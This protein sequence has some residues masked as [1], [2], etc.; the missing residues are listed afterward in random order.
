[1]TKII[2]TILVFLGLLTGCMN[3]PVKQDAGQ[4]STK[5]LKYPELGKK[6]HLVSNGIFLLKTDYISGYRYKLATELNVSLGFGAYSVFI[7]PSEE[8]IPSIMEGE[9]YH[10]VTSYALKQLIG[11]STKNVCLKITD[12][13]VVSMRYAPSAY[14]FTHE[15]KSGVKARRSEININN[16]EI[17]KI[18]IIFEGAT[19]DKILFVQKIYGN[20]LTIPLANK[21]IIINR[22]KSIIEMLG[23]VIEVYE[24]S[25]NS[26]TYSVKNWN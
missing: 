24:I 9:E 22:D 23:A 18:E 15:F 8:L 13:R 14:W 10:C 6:S 1:M 5:Y 25:A 7:S 26:I 21:P 3:A 16:S 19:Q 12:D 2:L 11:T 20:N 17:S 4:I